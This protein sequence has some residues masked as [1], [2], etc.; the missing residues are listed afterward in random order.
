MEKYQTQVTATLSNDGC[1]NLKK[2]DIIIGGEVGGRMT[3]KLYCRVKTQLTP[4]PVILGW[5]EN[6]E[7][8]EEIADKEHFA[9][10]GL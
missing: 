6:K 7:H 2:Q 4:D 5:W 3:W 9:E 10:Y 8:R 1:Y